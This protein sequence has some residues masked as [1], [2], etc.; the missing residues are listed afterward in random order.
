MTA[1]ALLLCVCGRLAVG[2]SSSDL[3]P[4]DS[5][6]YD[7]SSSSD[8]PLPAMPEPGFD[9][10]SSADAI[11]SSSSSNAVPP[12]S[13]PGMSSSPT[14]EGE[15]EDES[16]WSSA[17]HT[18]SYDTSA[19]DSSSPMTTA[20]S[21]GDDTVS[22]DLPSSSS[23]NSNHNNVAPSGI[24]EDSDPLSSADHVDSSSSGSSDAARQ[25]DKAS[26]S[27]SVVPAPDS[28][29]V[30]P[31]FT[32]AQRIATS[33]V[34][35]VIRDAFSDVLHNLWSGAN[36]CSWPHVYCS[37]DGVIVELRQQNLQGTMPAVPASVKKNDVFLGALVLSGNVGITGTLDASWNQLPHLSVFDVSG[38]SL[39]GALP[40]F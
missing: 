5:S 13:D 10:F 40:E 12:V 17:E 29:A 30:I 37:T 39:G 16:S 1:V 8:Y 15:G 34:L 11:P 36:F 22:S 7:L 19:I 21:D 3:T 25:D 23:I 18:T 9:V 38:C 31:F 4:P 2:A 35:Y 6:S 33:A 24:S 26:S 20:V 32:E 14:K 27:T 28:S